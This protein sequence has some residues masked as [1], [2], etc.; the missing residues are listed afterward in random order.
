VL[1]GNAIAAR[2]LPIENVPV[3]LRSRVLMCNRMRP[4][5]SAAAPAMTAALLLL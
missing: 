4:W 5:L 3:V 2:Q 1:V